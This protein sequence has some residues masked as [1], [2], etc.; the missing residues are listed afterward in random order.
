MTY[1]VLFIIS[2]LFSLRKIL[3]STR[4]IGH[5]W[6]YSFPYPQELFSKIHYY[7]SY[8]WV[9][10]NLGSIPTMNISQYLPNI[11]LSN[12]GK[13]FGSVFS[14][15]LLFIVIL[16]V[17]F[18]GFKKLL[19]YLIAKR[20]SNYLFS[21]LFAFSTFLFNEIIG[22]SW[23]MWISYAIS[24]LLSLFTLRF[25]INDNKKALIPLILCIVV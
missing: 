3:L 4:L 13:I 20:D 6:D 5:N 7:S 2:V 25:I 11:I 12:L 14:T 9:D 16:F 22:G 17:A 19:D 18:F 23:Y 8:T 24:P 1:I 21:F 10:H 15:K